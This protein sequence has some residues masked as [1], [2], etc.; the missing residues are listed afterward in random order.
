MSPGRVPSSILAVW[1]P[2][3]QS[4]A[5]S[6]RSSE[7]GVPAKNSGETPGRGQSWLFA[8]FWKWQPV[9]RIPKDVPKRLPRQFFLSELS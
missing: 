9:L 5:V 3:Q 7:I 2:S 6:Q 1:A 8:G 4:A